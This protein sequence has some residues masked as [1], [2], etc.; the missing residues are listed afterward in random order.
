MI[1][2]DAGTELSN[3]ARSTLKGHHMVQPGS[4]VVVGVSGG[5]DSVALLHVLT[6]L[7]PRMD[8]RVV[9]AHLDHALR[10][11]SAEDARFVSDTASALGVPVH[12][13]RADVREVSIREGISIEEAGRRCRYAFF[14]KVRTSVLADRIA[15]AHHLDDELETFF[16]RIF[17]GASMRGL[18][19]IPAVRGR[20]IRPFIQVTRQDI[21]RFLYE[22]GIPYRLD[23]TNLETDTDRNFIR[24]RLFPL[25]RERFPDFRLPAKRTADL[26]EQEDAFLNQEAM[27]VF[28]AAVARG[29]EAL[30]LDLPKVRACPEVL[31]AR[32]ILAALYELSG[33]DIRWQRVHVSSVAALAG[34]RRPSAA[35]NL[36]GGLIARREYDRLILSRATIAE[37]PSP[38]SIALAG[39]GRTLIPEAGMALQV[40]ILPRDA[41]SDVETPPD[42]AIFDADEVPFPLVVRPPQA[43]DR[44]RPWGF[45]GTRKLKKVLIDAKIPLRQRACLPLLTREEQIL[46]I[47]GVRRSSVAPVTPEAR[48]VLEIRLVEHS[49]GLD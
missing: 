44:F 32:V 18:G 19:G 30:T 4:R 25:I 26:I 43:G 40:R 1:S 5:S 42:V 39:P 6:A 47:V 49:E 24:N 9:A 17:R 2:M 3:I 12:V 29:T 45:D 36:P 8:F 20:I 35:V 10:A 11:E 34:S 7:S 21:L 22:Q 13:Q 37:E 23:R 27:K 28:S 41:I 15:T 33:P 31:R 14:E 46:W 16:L 48:R 38:F